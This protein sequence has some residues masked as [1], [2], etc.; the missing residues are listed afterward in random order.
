[1]NYVNIMDRDYHFYKKK[2]YFVIQTII[3]NSQP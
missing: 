1:M 2:D 3:L